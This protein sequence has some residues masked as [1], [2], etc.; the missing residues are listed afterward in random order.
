[1][2]ADL[3]ISWTVGAVMRCWWSRCAEL[4]DRILN[5]YSWLHVLWYLTITL[6]IPRPTHP[7]FFPAVTLVSP[8]NCCV[9]W[10][11]Q[12]WQTN[13]CFA[14]NRD[15]LQ[16]IE[17]DRRLRLINQ[18]LEE[19][20]VQQAGSLHA[21]P[22]KPAEHSTYPSIS[23]SRSQLNEIDS[24]FHCRR[25]LFTQKTRQRP[26]AFPLTVFCVHSIIIN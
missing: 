19:M 23:D 17:R 24:P 11:S 16:L 18:H 10:N 20:K 14:Q 26:E 1:M 7:F 2:Y 25:D 6:F 5:A 8:I 13:N 15:L 21:S 22:E 9:L 3:L 4:C 12:R